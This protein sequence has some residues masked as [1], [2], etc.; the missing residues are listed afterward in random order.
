MKYIRTILTLI[1]LLVVQSLYSQTAN[2]TSG[3]RFVIISCSSGQFA[4]THIL[5]SETGR[6]WVERG[7]ATENPTFV[8]CVY[9]LPDG[10]ISLSPLMR[11]PT[12]VADV[13]S[14]STN[15]VQVPVSQ[16]QTLK[17]DIFYANAELDI[18]RSQLLKIK[19][20]QQWAVF[21]GWDKLGRPFFGPPQPPSDS[22]ATTV[23]GNIN[24]ME[25]INEQKEKQLQLLLSK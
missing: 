3:E 1:P 17:D 20:G 7:Q 9:Q 2:S 25:Q 21:Q 19:A 14:S 5:D 6:V 24:Q 23:Q 4:E 18:W 10:K 11:E 13:N 12:P 22:A 8:P 15:D 16:L